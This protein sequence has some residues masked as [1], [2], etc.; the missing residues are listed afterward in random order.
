MFS[1]Y[2][3]I[4][5]HCILKTKRTQKC[6]YYDIIRSFQRHNSIK[7]DTIYQQMKCVSPEAK[8][9]SGKVIFSWARIS[10]SWQR[11]PS[12]FQEMV[13]SFSNNGSYLWELTS[14]SWYLMSNGITTFE[15][16]QFAPLRVMLNYSLRNY[17]CKK[18]IDK[19]CNMVLRW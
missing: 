18:L 8:L 19:L 12:H 4:Q 11:I 5:F 7:C 3:H 16:S 14:K 13:A 10:F 15:A 1:S 9:I 2:N 17:K 6:N